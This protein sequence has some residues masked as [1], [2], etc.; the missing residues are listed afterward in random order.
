MEKVEFVVVGAG[1][2]GLATAMVLAEAGAE[3]LVVERGD[4]AGSKNV[5]GGRL[6]LGPI[7]PYLPDL[8]DKAPLERRVVKERLAM[9]T[10]ASSITVE[11]NSDRLRAPPYPSYT[12]LRAT[13]DQWFADQA[14]E[15]GALIISG[16]KV[17]DLVIEE[18]RVV[19][20]VSAGDEIHADA[21]VAAD[22]ALSF[23][24]EK[25]GLRKRLVAKNYA[26]AAKEVIELPAQTI[27]D[28]FGL[29]EGEGAAQLFFGSLTQG[30]S[31][32]GFLYTNRESLS[33]GLV[34]AI[35]DLMALSNP[36]QNE[37][38][39]PVSPHELLEA[40][41]VRSEIRPLIAGGHP[42]EYSGH[43]IP[44]GGFHALPRLVTDGMIV[45]GDAAGF[46]LNMGVTVR[47]LDFALA[48]GVMAARA[49]LRARARGDFSAAS[50]IYY[51][52]L[53]KDSFVWQ[54]LKT[55]QHTP[56]FFANPR[57]FEFYP[58]VVCDLL[59]RIMWIGEEPKAKLSKTVFRAARQNFLRVGVLK[60]LLTTWKI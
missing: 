10:S 2:A 49:L 18:G 59:E 17:D 3:V 27:E 26:V 14:A 57:L 48:S 56:S 46:A 52:T 6:Y 54:D 13:F 37:E 31:G 50:L 28:R 36:R 4:Y 32:G 40:F 19:G 8:W 1:V 60:D 30:M 51:E 29:A 47:G 24:A 23:M 25:A 9:M 15:R 38:Q 22:G 41:K 35:H 44:E 21:I 33:L 11:L 53:L 58:S 42:V 34:V 39:L 16:Y 43:V 5:S 45:A 20:I 7:R 12:L 55:F